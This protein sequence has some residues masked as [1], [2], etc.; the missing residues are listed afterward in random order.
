MT[1]DFAL[2]ERGQAWIKAMRT[3]FHSRPFE[4]SPAARPVEVGNFKIM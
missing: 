1:E 4:E 3:H 2:N